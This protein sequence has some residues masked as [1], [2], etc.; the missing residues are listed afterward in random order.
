MRKRASVGQGSNS[1]KEI[2]ICAVEVSQ[3]EAPGTKE[4]SA[5]TT[6]REPSVR[7]SVDQASISVHLMPT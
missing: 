6:P 3:T 4:S 7:Y 1:G 5:S 2:C